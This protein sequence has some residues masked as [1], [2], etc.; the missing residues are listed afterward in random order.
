MGGASAAIDEVTLEQVQAAWLKY[1]VQAEPVEI[2]VKKG[3]PKAEEV[4]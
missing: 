3:E 1:V 4:Q 2:F